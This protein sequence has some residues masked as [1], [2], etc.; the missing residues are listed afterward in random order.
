MNLNTKQIKVKILLGA[1]LS[2]GFTSCQFVNK[3]K[4]P[5]IDTTGLYGQEFQSSDTT[6]IASMPWKEYFQ[7]PLLQSL[8]VEGLE[9]NFDLRI[10]VERIKQSEAQLMMAKLAYLPTLGINGSG[11]Q[12]WVSR[13]SAGEKDVFGPKD[14]KYSL[15]FAAT[16]EIDVWGKINRQYRSTDAQY[17]ASVESK[18][19]I[20]TS[21]IA[22]IANAYYSLLSLD[23]Q[24]KVTNDMVVLLEET[25][26]MMESMMQAGNTNS[27]AVEQTKASLYSAQVSIPTLEYNIQQIENTI[28]NLIGRKPG[29]VMRSKLDS[30]SVPTSMAYGVPAQLLSNRPDVKAAELSF[31]SAFELT[32]VAQASFYPSISL[33]SGFLGY[34]SNTVSKFFRPENLLLTL[35]GNLTQPIFAKGQ[36][37]GNLKTAKANQEIA[38]LTFEQTVLSAGMEVS[39]ILNEYEKSMSKNI[40]RGKQVTSLSKAAY[41]TQEL[42]KYG[43][44]SSYLEVITAQQNLL[45]AQLDQISDKLDQLQC[46][47]NLYK[48]LGGG[49]N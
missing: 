39:N 24:L 33:S 38:L 31:K 7:D 11:Q 35:V 47:V 41:D 13:N 43:E 45:T 19:A 48:A 2:I 26:K 17:L 37:I 9:N 12:G 16:W 10:A 1:M 14:N 40:T 34:G 42:F 4:A 28:C 25:T 8:I 23:K 6:T 21:L 32:N 22:N 36:L 18:N 49:V 30:Q 20:Q 27:A 46:T 5:E 29:S 3:Y 15:G 44:S